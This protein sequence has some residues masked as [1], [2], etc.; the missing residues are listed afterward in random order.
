MGPSVDTMNH[1]LMVLCCMVL[2]QQPI[3]DEVVIG[4]IDV[5]VLSDDV[6]CFFPEETF[7]EIMTSFGKPHDP[8][9]AGSF[10]SLHVA[11]SSTG[12]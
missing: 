1:I 7:S 9:A 6:P 10:L 4:Q 11:D 2:E 5:H 3:S 8:P 12:N